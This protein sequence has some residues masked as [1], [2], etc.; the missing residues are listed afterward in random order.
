MF[1]NSTCGHCDAGMQK[2]DT[3]VA[4]D[5]GKSSKASKPDL[6]ASEVENVEVAATGDTA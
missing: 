4:P 3:K 5:E 6:T 2:R 1:L